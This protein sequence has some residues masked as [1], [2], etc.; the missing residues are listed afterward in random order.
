MKICKEQEV[1]A[2]PK[3]IEELIIKLLDNN[4]INYNQA[5]LILNN[6]ENRMFERKFTNGRTNKSIR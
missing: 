6:V 4:D 3:G 2:N 5:R 1:L